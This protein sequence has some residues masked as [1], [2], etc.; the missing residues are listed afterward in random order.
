MSTV[1][2]SE[3]IVVGYASLDSVT[4]TPVFR[5]VDATSILLRPMRADEPAAG[6]IAHLVS[7]AASASNEVAVTALSWVGADAGGELWRA[8][9]R[10]SGASDD[11][12]V[13]VGDRSPSATMLEIGTGGTLCFFDPGTCHPERL[14]DRQ[15]DLLGRASAVLLTVAPTSL[16]RHLLDVLADEAILIWAV[17]RDEDAY[18]DDLVD[19]LI[20]RADAISFTRGERPFLERRAPLAAAAR[21]GALLLETLGADGVRWA[22]AGTDRAGSVAV[23][24]VDAPDTTGAGDTFIGSAAAELARRGGRDALSD[25]SD[26][27][28]DGLAGRATGAARD[29]LLSRVGEHH[30]EHARRVASQNEG[31]T[32]AER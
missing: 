18:G 26:D 12:V 25:L 6:G 4:S 14:D 15:V 23:V 21:P 29:L 28:L 16:T 1:P 20:A 27:D 30:T 11:G 10:R 17:K 13:V 2:P 5:G 19:R 8:A 32:H 22:V 9:L 31:V 3:L 24:P 7:A